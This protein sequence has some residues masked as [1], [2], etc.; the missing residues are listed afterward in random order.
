MTF[1]YK[2]L[3]CSFCILIGLPFPAAAQHIALDAYETRPSGEAYAQS[4]RFRSIDTDVVYLDPTQPPP[5]LETQ[6]APPELETPPQPENGETSRSRF[7]ID[8]DIITLVLIVIVSLAIMGIGYLIIIYGGRL[9]VSFARR[10]D[11]AEG[12]NG[13]GHLV[14][15]DMDAS[16]PSSLQAILAMSDRRQ[17]LVALCRGLL[18]RGVAAQGI[19]FQRSWTDRD[20]LGRIPQNLDH[21]DALRALVFASEKVQF[22]GRDV[23]EEQFQDHV[24]TLKPLWAAAPT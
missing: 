1:K 16:L 15:D 5:A 18:A 13:N 21:R 22:G 19:L 4:I 10:P 11:D 9:P 3:V 17:A 7:T 24:N 12:G 6:E 20:A 23:S 2:A 14:P 8:E